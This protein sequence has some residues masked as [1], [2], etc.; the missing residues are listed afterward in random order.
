[1]QTWGRSVHAQAVTANLRQQGWAATTLQR[2]QRKQKA[3]AVV[4]EV[5]TRKGNAAVKLQSMVRGRLVRVNDME[6]HRQSSA[7]VKLQSHA[8]RRAALG[9]ARKTRAQDQAATW[10]VFVLTLHSLGLNISLS[11]RI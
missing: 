4:E 5:R 2:A 1:M 7:A 11:I 9:I 6:H 3:N 10:Y 8:R